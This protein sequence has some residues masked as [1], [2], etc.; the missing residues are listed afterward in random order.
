MKT[1]TEQ[2]EI[3][4]TATRFVTP[5]V[6]VAPFTK[7]VPARNYKTETVEVG[8]GRYNYVKRQVGTGTYRTVTRQVGTGK[9]ETVTYTDPNPEHGTYSHDPSEH[10]DCPD[11]QHKAPLPKMWFYPVPSD[12]VERMY[13]FTLENPSRGSLVAPLVGV[14]D[15]ADS[16]TGCSKPL[17]LVKE[18]EGPSKGYLSSWINSVVEKPIVRI[19]TKMNETAHL[20]YKGLHLAVCTFGA[21]L[22]AIAGVLL[23][24]KYANHLRKAIKLAEDIKKTVIKF[25]GAG[26]ASIALALLEDLFCL[27]GVDPDGDDTI[28]LKTVPPTTHNDYSSGA[29]TLE[30]KSF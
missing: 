7:T 11:G 8:T 25:V 13:K 26:L 23:T 17:P 24:T 5:L 16:H 10:G 30:G 9:F 4:K 27:Y 14:W 18:S 22:V 15:E 2:V 19:T 29:D 21:T 1:V 12:T 28:S 3:M 6:R 20:A